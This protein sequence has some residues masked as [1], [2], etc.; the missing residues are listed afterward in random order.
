[1]MNLFDDYLKVLGM[2]IIESALVPES[3]DI[4]TRI[5]WITR[6][7]DGTLIFRYDLRK[8]GSKYETITRNRSV[9]VIPGMGIIMHPEDAAIIKLSDIT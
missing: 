4:T 9:I 8:H 3:K 1:M 7:S 6:N 2:P 5:E